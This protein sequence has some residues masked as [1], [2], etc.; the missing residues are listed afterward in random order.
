MKAKFQV[1]RS[2]IAELQEFACQTIVCQHRQYLRIWFTIFQ[3]PD[4]KGFS[5]G[6]H[7]GLATAIIRSATAL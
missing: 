7:S 5:A 4:L 1:S 2:Q 3:H 6:E